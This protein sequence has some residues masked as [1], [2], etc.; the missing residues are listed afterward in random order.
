MRDDEHDDALV[1]NASDSAQIRKAGAKQKR[2]ARLVELAYAEAL[3]TRWGK[4]LL[5]AELDE[6]GMFR[7]TFHENALVMAFKAGG[8]NRGLKMMARIDA[9]SPT[10]VVDVTSFYRKEMKNA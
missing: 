3:T 9:V 6:A 8:H 4:I 5:G 1:G 10:G 2:Q 7:S